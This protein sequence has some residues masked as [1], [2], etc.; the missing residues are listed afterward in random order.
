MRFVLVI[1][2]NKN[3]H[4]IIPKALNSINS[5]TLVGIRSIPL[6]FYTLEITLYTV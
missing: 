3:Q 1:D 5:I 2:K 4:G 6:C